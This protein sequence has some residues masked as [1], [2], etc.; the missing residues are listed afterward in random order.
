MRADW[1]FVALVV[2]C[3]GAPSSNDALR[4]EPAMSRPAETISPKPSGLPIA[5]IT[6]QKERNAAQAS[7][8]SVPSSLEDASPSSDGTAVSITGCLTGTGNS[9]TSRGA[10]PSAEGSD[11]TVR[12][13]GEGTRIVVTHELTHVCCLKGTVHTATE[14]GLVRIEE[15]L[16]GVPCR[17]M[18]RSTL[19]TSVALSL[20][21][22]TV[23][24]VLVNGQTRS[25]IHQE[26]VSLRP[27]RPL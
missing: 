7:G 21:D 24:V 3:C 6:A 11:D 20:G 15:S 18:C 13:R 22:Y 26:S 9:S 12:A 17:C 19:R 27:M 14:D 16:T 2:S 1:I 25:L 4:D 23:E 10:S 8:N 5:E